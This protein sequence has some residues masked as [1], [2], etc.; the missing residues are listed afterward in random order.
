MISDEPH[1]HY[2]KP[3][4]SGKEDT[5]QN[6]KEKEQKENGWNRLDPAVIIYNNH[7]PISTPPLRYNH[8]HDLVPVWLGYN[9]RY[10]TTNRRTANN[11]RM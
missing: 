3:T 8:N 11:Q 5:K 4:S 1:V 6:P 9:H 7:I 10:R 2:V